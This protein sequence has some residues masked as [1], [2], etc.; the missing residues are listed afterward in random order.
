MLQNNI[1][2]EQG[3]FRDPAGT[4]FF[5]DGAVY[6]TISPNVLPEIEKLFNSIFFQNLINSGK[7]IKSNLVKNT[8]DVC[9][10]FILHHDKIPFVSYPYEWSFSMLKDAALLTLNI[11][12]D[13]I[14]NGYILKDGTAWNITYYNGSM[15]FFDVLSIEKYEEGQVWNGYQQFCQ[16]FLNPLFLKSYKNLNFNDYFR[17]LLSGIDIKLMSKI[18][19]LSDI[20]RPGIFKHVFLN[21]FLTNNKK[22][23]S[24]TINNKYKL[25]KIALLSM[26]EGLLSVVKKLNYNNADSVWV[27]YSNKNT[28]TNADEVIKVD[29]VKKLFCSI[30]NNSNIIDLGCNTG[31]YS[32]LSS[33]FHNI[34]SCDIDNDCIEQIYKK[35]STEKNKSI[36]PI[37]INLMNPSPNVGW[38]LTERKS[39]YDR[40]NVNCF[41]SLALI[42]HICIANNVPIKRF[43]AFLRRIAPRGIVE[44]VEKDDPMVQFLLRNRKDIFSTYTWEHFMESVKQH[45]DLKEFITLNDGHRKLCW[46]EPKII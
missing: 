38:E 41:L 30:Q 9:G 17:G 16:E 26:I 45:F 43:V 42:H 27:D 33:E 6:R 24:S 39:I 11:L 20:F 31:K 10:K 7:V 22:I 1:V 2:Y 23:A 18:F 8:F 25:P 5:S 44:W 14:N 46:L 3:S 35:V 12:K 40:L 28:Y 4:V 32:Y 13:C 34:I 36:T 15:I 19:N 29:F 21:A 37:V